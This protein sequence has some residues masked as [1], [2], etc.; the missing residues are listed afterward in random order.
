MTFQRGQ[1]VRHPKCPD[2][3]IGEVL[4]QEGETVHVHFGK[5]GMKKLN[6]QYVSLELAEMPAGSRNEKKGIATLPNVDMGRVEAFCLQFHEEM[7]DNRSNTD[8]GKMGLNVLRDMRERGNLSRSTKHQLLAW[9]HTEGNAY[10]RGV[11]L[12]QQICRE[13]YGLVPTREEL[14]SETR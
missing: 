5:E 12:A 2:W 6:T 4:S 11:G 14:E 7:K 1:W 13:V 9:C 3:G 10:Q 8:D